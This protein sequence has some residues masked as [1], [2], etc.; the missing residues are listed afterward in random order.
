MNSGHFAC[1]TILLRNMSSMFYDLIYLFYM[2]VILCIPCCFELRIFLS[3][4]LKKQHV[5]F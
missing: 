5:G 4:P 3:Q 2:K 1:Y